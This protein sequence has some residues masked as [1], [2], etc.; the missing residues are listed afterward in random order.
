MMLAL[1]GCESALP[2]PLSTGSVVS[3]VCART[4]DPQKDRATDLTWNFL[5]TDRQI[6][7]G[8]T[9]KDY[10]EGSRCEIVRYLNGKYLDH[11]SVPV[12]KPISNTVFFTWTL[13]K[14][15]VSHLPGPYKVK[16]FI[17]GRYTKEVN[18]TVG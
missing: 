12:K 16:V 1:L 4:Y 18:Y 2:Y 9:L 15:G 13:A 14:P 3:V 8:V 10:P 6:V 17:N 7:L 5:A 11:G